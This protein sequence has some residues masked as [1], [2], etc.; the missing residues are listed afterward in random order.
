MELSL[1]DLGRHFPARQAALCEKEVMLVLLFNGAHDSVKVTEHLSEVNLKS[2]SFPLLG[3]K[4]P[5]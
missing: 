2:V 1:S 4:H 3:L 5:A